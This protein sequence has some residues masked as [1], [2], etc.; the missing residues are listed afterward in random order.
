MNQRKIKQSF[1]LIC[2][3]LAGLMPFH[4]SL[5]EKE[6]VPLFQIVAPN[7]QRLNTQKQYLPEE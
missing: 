7:Y 2:L 5:A 1:H 3:I 4:V 6:N